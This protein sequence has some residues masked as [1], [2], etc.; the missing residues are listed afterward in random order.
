MA[1]LV[2]RRGPEQAQQGEVVLSVQQQWDPDQRAAHKHYMH[3]L[4]GYLA[5]IREAALEMFGGKSD[6]V[7]ETRAMGQFFARIP[8][9]VDH[10]NA[11]YLRES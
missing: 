10:C 3:E 2:E 4:D 5:S 8:P 6:R 7:R 11:A 1:P 9:L